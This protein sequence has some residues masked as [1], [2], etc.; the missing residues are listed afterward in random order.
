MP[1]SKNE[2]TESDIIFSR[3]SLALARSQD[4]I[5][6]WLPPPPSAQNSKDQAQGL[7]GEDARD[8]EEEGGLV[9]LE[10]EEPET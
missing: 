4:I 2:P 10:A 7:G 5:K 1:K 3:A 8:G 6:S 9:G